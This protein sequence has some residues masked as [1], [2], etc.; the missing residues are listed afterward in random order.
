MD[1]FGWFYAAVWV[2]F[3]QNLLA[4]VMFPHMLIDR[5]NVDGQSMYIAILKLV[6][7]VAGVFQVSFILNEVNLLLISLGVGI[8]LF[9]SIYVYMLL[10]KFKQL[11]L[12]PWTRKSLET[13]VSVT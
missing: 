13:A 5:N 4:S 3:S 1:V 12:N 8:F 10:S 6:G 11:G 2:S 7:T 9:D